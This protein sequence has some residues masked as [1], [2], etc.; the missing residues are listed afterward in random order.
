M[1]SSLYIK[2]KEVAVL[3]IIRVLIFEKIESALKIF[4]IRWFFLSVSKDKKKYQIGNLGQ[5]D[6][7]STY[8]S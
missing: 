8:Y 4:I 1:V 6:Y 5:V 7:I 2:K 3:R